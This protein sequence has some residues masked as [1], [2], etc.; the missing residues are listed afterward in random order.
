[1]ALTQVLC[2]AGSLDVLEVLGSSDTILPMLAATMTDSKISEPSPEN[3]HLTS[4][5]PIAQA[6]DLQTAAAR[7]PNTKRQVDSSQSTGPPQQQLDPDALQQ[8]PQQQAAKS[9]KQKHAKRLAPV[10]QQ[11]NVPWHQQHHMQTRRQLGHQVAQLQQFNGCQQHEQMSSDQ[12]HLSGADLLQQQQPEHSRRLIEQSETIQQPQQQAPEQLLQQAPEHLQQQELLQSQQQIPERIQ[13]QAPAQ[14]LQNVDK[15]PQQQASLQSKQQ[16][17]E[18][19]QQ[20]A[21]A[22]L[23]QHIDERLQQQQQEP[24]LAAGQQQH[25]GVEYVHQGIHAAQLALQ[26]QVACPTQTAD[27]CQARSEP[28]ESDHR[29]GAFGRQESLALTAAIKTSELNASQSVGHEEEQ[30]VAVD[31]QSAQTEAELRLL[32]PTVPEPSPSGIAQ[33]LDLSDVSVVQAFGA[34]ERHT[35]RVVEGQ[36][37]RNLNQQA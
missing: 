6:R 1:M 3:A 2:F 20:Q 23:L 11:H 25:A 35:L 27:G 22:Q 9:Q 34:P 31:Q 37:P 16:V 36:L 8:R 21:P 28:Q 7:Q 30:Q 14:L 32:N 12:D 29:Q 13:Q 4:V 17:P 26:T 15:Q 24:G 18:G 5:Q 33:E 10:Q 19:V